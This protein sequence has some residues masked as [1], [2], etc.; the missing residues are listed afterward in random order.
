MVSEEMVRIDID[1]F[2]DAA[3]TQLNDTPIVPGS[4]TP[5]RFPSIHPFAAVGVLVG[6]EDSAARL[7]Q[8]FLLREEL[9]VG[10]QRF[11][12]HAFRSQ[13]DKPR[14]RCYR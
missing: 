6:D 13:I 11:A 1:L 5:A 12:A 4:A 7:Q 3:Q 2:D 14:W 9:V 8:I 10:E